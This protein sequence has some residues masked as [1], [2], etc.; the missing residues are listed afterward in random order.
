MRKAALLLFA[1]FPLLLQSAEPSPF[2]DLSS[3]PS[4]PEEFKY[5]VFQSKITA[6]SGEDRNIL[7]RSYYYDYRTHRYKKQP[8]LPSAAINALDRILSDR[9]QSDG[10]FKKIWDGF[11]RIN[12]GVQQRVAVLLKRVVRELPLGALRIS[13]DGRALWYY[14]KATGG[15]RILFRRG[16]GFMEGEIPCWEPSS[17]VVLPLAAGGDLGAVMDAKRQALCLRVFNTS[18]EGG[19]TAVIPFASGSRLSAVPL[20][21]RRVLLAWQKD[22]AVNGGYYDGGSGK[23]RR[24]KPFSGF[25]LPRQQSTG[26]ALY[27]TKGGK[28]YKVCWDGSRGVHPPREMY[29]LAKD[30]PHS[31]FVEKDRAYFVYRNP[32]AVYAG[33]TA[34]GPFRK[35]F[36]P[37]KDGRLLYC[38]R[39]TFLSRTGKVWSLFDGKKTVGIRNLPSDSGRVAADLRS[40]ILQ[41]FYQKQAGGG[42]LY[43]LAQPLGNS[44]ERMERSVVFGSS[45]FLLIV[46][47]LFISFVYGFIHS[48]GPGHGKALVM[49]YFVERPHHG[50][51]PPVRLALIV[52]TTHTG[53]A[54]LLATI[55]QLVLAVTPNQM[56]IR[57]WFTVFSAAV[58]I[59]LGV[60]MLVDRFR[61]HG[62]AGEG[63]AAPSGKSM[64]ALGI[65][66][67]IVPCPLAMGIMVISILNGVFLLGMLSVF[68]MSAGMFL[69]LLLVGGLTSRSRDRLER[70]MEGRGRLTEV[71]GKVA[72]VVSSLII[73]VL[74]VALLTPVL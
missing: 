38:G 71:L 6:L 33:D 62:A 8:G 35:Y 34:G 40:G 56:A 63:E 66:A 1:F 2:A 30:A 68:G 53:S 25:A 3:G 31:L 61:K 9:Q 27:L 47:L 10:F 17:A 65:A 13:S 28:I 70:I 18:A 7:T 72:G 59:L 39:G 4:A 21:D 46:L 49:A 16:S 74:G 37:R 60:Y 20:S 51:L 73:V 43:H 57:K 42:P 14:S 5:A 22:G 69:L 29:A 55:F 23:F 41:L 44:A 15:L 67:G 48:S 12:S 50:W 26:N 36:V 54:F 24:F 32:P 64:F 45:P 52:S 11:I 19:Q 58:V